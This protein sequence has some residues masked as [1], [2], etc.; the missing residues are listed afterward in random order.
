[1]VEKQT[2]KRS[3]HST[4]RQE[5]AFHTR[6]TIAR[7]ALDLFKERGYR[8]ASVDAIA[9]AAGVAPE[10]IY[11]IFSSKR[12]L[13][14]YLLDTAVGGDEAPLKILDRPEHA[15]LFNLADAHA[16]ITH[17][18]AGYYPVM[19]RAAP[20]FAIIAEAAKTEPELADLQVNMREERFANMARLV[21]AMER[22]SRLRLGQQAATETLW[23]LTSPEL[24]LLL[25]VTRGWN[26]AK[27]VGW[28]SDSLVRLLLE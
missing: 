4:R 9:G 15:V 14:H 17:F 27:Y 24:F 12:E 8:G 26:E 5:S 20:V 1:M 3:Y 28:L 18:A 2:R 16:I 23:A 21:R 13:L 22:V 19:L 7:A 25:N 6:Q 10:T 11:A